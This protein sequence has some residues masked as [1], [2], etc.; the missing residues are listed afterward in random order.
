M[1]RTIHSKIRAVAQRCV[2]SDTLRR[3]GIFVR[4]L[5]RTIKTLSDNPLESFDLVIP[6]QGKMRFALVSGEPAVIL[7]YDIDEQIERMIRPIG[8]RIE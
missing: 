8:N 4:P 5:I 3:R 1:E 7:S 6:Q 2:L